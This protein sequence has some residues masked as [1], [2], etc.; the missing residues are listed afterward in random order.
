VVRIGW[1]SSR[2]GRSRWAPLGL[3]ALALGGCALLPAASPSSSASAPAPPSSPAASAA[4]ADSLLVEP[5]A[6]MGAIYQ[7]IGSARSSV[8]LVMYELEDRQA[9]TLLAGAEGRGVRVRVIL[10]QAYARSQNQPAYAYLSGH[11]VAVRWSST[12]VDITHQKTLVVD[13]RTAYVMTGNLT[14]QYYASTRDVIVVD[15]DPADVAAIEQTFAADY[16]GVAASPSAGDDLV[17]SPGSTAALTSIIGS[18]THRLLVE[19]EEM[20]DRDVVSALESA[21]RRGVEVDVCMTDS[22]SWTTQFR[23]LAEAG[24]RV[25]TYAPTAALYIHA[26]VMVAD[27]GSADQVAFAGSENFSFTSLTANRELGVVLHSPSLVGQLA[28]V[29]EQDFSGATPTT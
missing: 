7:A 25:R 14:A 4:G 17:W 15:A 19:N 18:A 11:G 10:D 6:G 8:D 1:A 3:V 16:A 22:S 27:P 12:R 28:T 13:G 20:S 2:L 29:L 23:E 9:E 21:A 5:Q 26:K 24:V